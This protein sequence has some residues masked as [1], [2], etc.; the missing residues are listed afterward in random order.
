MMTI[1]GYRGNIGHK[2]DFDVPVSGFV[3][4]YD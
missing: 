3:S 4:A 2:Q 1:L